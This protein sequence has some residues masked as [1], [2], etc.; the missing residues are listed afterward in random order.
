VIPAYARKYAFHRLYGSDVTI[1]DQ[2]YAIPPFLGEPAFSIQSAA[3]GHLA[4]TFPQLAEY[5]RF[6]EELR[7]EVDA[8]TGSG[9]AL[10]EEGAWVRSVAES[11]ERY[12]LVA[13]HAD[14]LRVASAAELGDAAID[15]DLLPRCSTEEL[16]H[17]RCLVRPPDK[18]EPMRWVQGVSLI[19]GRPRWV[20]AV[21]THLFLQELPG[22]RFWPQISTGVA[23]HTDL[24]AALVSAASEMIER[25]A[26]T[27]TWLGRLPLPEIDARAGRSPALHESLRRLEGASVEH[28][29]FEA[30]TDLGV[31]TVFAVQRS[32][33]DP[34]IKL[35]V[36]CS[37]NVDPE[38]AL[39]KTI[40]E[41]SSM[42]VAM[43]NEAEL[44][45]N[46][47]DFYA[48][49]HGATFY[50]RRGAGDCFDFLLRPSALKTPSEMTRLGAGAVTPAVELRQLLARLE[51]RGFDA[52]AVDLTTEEVR[53]TGLW[54]VRVVIPGLLPLVTLQ[55]AR[56]LG[57]PRLYAQASALRG[58]PFTEADVNP[59]PMPFA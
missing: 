8:V 20:P 27:L 15:L 44:P 21:M 23:A 34:R 37:T 1:V 36:S 24:A 57:T 13:H 28:R 7:S 39:T 56:M 55:R 10:D 33:H 4:R 14:E 16:R 54:V 48:L 47:S 30:T 45:D 22:E 41:A 9:V 29:F 46:V 3:L 42:R 17:P 6:S 49:H 51:E 18:H 12:C 5:A 40:W 38:A 35:V 2:S 58:A 59:N 53:E 50:A 25:D 43:R 19:S 11:V 31:P 32:P 52:I 26:I